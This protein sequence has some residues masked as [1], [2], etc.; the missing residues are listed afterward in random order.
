MAK[1]KQ[2]QVP[3]KK[4]RHRKRI[5]L[6]T[7]DYIEF[8]P[9]E[10]PFTSGVIEDSGITYVE[11]NLNMLFCPRCKRVLRIDPDDVRVEMENN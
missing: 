8:T 9:D 2:M 4:C 10:E 6:L 3:K 7:A 1:K 5:A 11:C